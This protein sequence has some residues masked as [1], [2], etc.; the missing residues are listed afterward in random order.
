MKHAK[1][2]TVYPS[3]E[4]KKQLKESACNSDKMSN[5]YEKVCKVDIINI[6]QN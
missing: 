2:R 1:K 4:R 3:T 6:P 5:L